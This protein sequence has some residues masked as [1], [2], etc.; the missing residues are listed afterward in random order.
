MK[1]IKFNVLFLQ[2][3]IFPA[4]AKTF[5]ARFVFASVQ[6]L[7]HDTLVSRLTALS[8][9][10]D[11]LSSDPGPFVLSFR[12]FSAYLQKCLKFNCEDGLGG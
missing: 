1:R 2:A 5:G 4:L 6:K 11:V 7:I 12:S 3:R 9:D 10:L 8:S